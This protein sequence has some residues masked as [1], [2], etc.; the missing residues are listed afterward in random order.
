MRWAGLHAGL[1]NGCVGQ[2]HMSSSACPPVAVRHPVIVRQ[3]EASIIFRASCV[4]PTWAPSSL[5]GDDVA[6]RLYMVSSNTSTRHLSII[7]Y[8]TKSWMMLPRWACLC[9]C[10]LSSAFFSKIYI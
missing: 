7:C 4:A 3:P 8:M 5:S 10:A 6:C 9:S 2:Q 1:C